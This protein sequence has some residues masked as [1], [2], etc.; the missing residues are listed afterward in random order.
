MKR[1]IDVIAFGLPL[2]IFIVG[3]ISLYNAPYV[4]LNLHIT[5]DKIYLDDMNQTELIAIGEMQVRPTDFTNDQDLI[6]C[7]DDFFHFIGFQYYLSG[8]IQ[9]GKD[10]S[11]HTVHNHMLQT[12]KMRPQ[13]YPLERLYDE[14]ILFFAAFF[15][16]IIPLVLMRK[17]RED[18]RITVFI[19]LLYASSSVFLSFAFW[20]LRSISLDPF[21]TLFILSINYLSFIY[22]PI[23]FLHFFLIFPNKKEFFATRKM[24]YLLYSL[25]ILV[26]VVYVPRIIYEA[27]QI[28][29]LFAIIAGIAMMVHSFFTSSA[30]ERAQIKWVLWGTILF[31][32][33]MLVTYIFPLL[34][35]MSEW[36]NYQI[37]ALAFALLP[38][39]ITFAIEKYRLMDIDSLIDNTLIY[40]VTLILLIL[41]DA[42][43]LVALNGFVHEH[44]SGAFSAFLAL[45]IAITFYSPFRQFAS[46]M[47]QKVLKRGHYH[48][49]EIALKLAKTIIPLD[50][51]EQIIQSG[52]DSIETTL[53]PLDTQVYLF[54]SK[55]EPLTGLPINVSS[56]M[57][58]Q[59]PEYLFKIPTN[60][61]LP[62]EYLS[63]VVAP[64]VNG[65][66]VLGFVFC[67]EKQSQQLY[68]K[69]DIELI[70][71]VVTQMAIGI[72]GVRTKEL[73]KKDKEKMIREIHDGIGG[74]ATNISLISQMAKES[75]DLSYIIQS[76]STI[77]ELSHDAVFEIRCILQSLDISTSTFGEFIDTFRRYAATMLEPHDIA[78]KLY[79]ENSNPDF[80]PSAI[81]TL[82]VFR[83]YRE[84]LTNIIKY[85]HATTVESRVYVSSEKFGI[86]I[87]DNG[88]GFE[89]E[90]EGRGVR[91]MYQRAKEIGASLSIAS[92]NGVKIA[93]EISLLDTK[94]DA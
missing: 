78:F 28:L 70:D 56:L 60:F 86:M 39:S 58:L 9:K 19:L 51:I 68:T 44:L 20:S 6:I 22:F 38:I 84:A 14:L 69:K 15:C 66:N 85:A 53:H 30:V 61:D 26:S 80:L 41:L 27:E 89:G 2:F 11:L 4:N 45:W 5:E 32:L 67:A 50:K 12:V 36:Y 65:D 59:R 25:P 46:R 55:S 35:Y 23:F 57:D 34:G 43:V 47:V 73:A 10:I 24:V 74:I 40:T 82:N 79:V 90:Q 81:V 17:K 48:S 91:H 33:I 3:I 64:I 49:H 94:E 83:I 42:L 1:K 18:S 8:Y 88:I 7:R 21:T 87:Q 29:F 13:S 52:I 62:K 71:M 93:L 77:S 75:S 16:L 31:S 72:E 54:K 63:G 92:E 76:I 37:P